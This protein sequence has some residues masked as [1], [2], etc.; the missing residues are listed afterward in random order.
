M[1]D[2]LFV[3]YIILDTFILYTSSRENVSFA[4]VFLVMFPPYIRP[5]TLLNWTLLSK[6]CN[7]HLSC[8]PNAVYSA[9]YSLR[10]IKAALLWHCNCSCSHFLFISHRLIIWVCLWSYFSHQCWKPRA[11]SLFSINRYE[12][13]CQSP[14]PSPHP[15]FISS[16]PR[17]EPS[18]PGHFRWAAGASC[19][20]N[21][22]VRVFHRGLWDSRCGMVVLGCGC[23][24]AQGA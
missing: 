18:H 16:Q 13:T 12:E 21:S 5:T 22:A 6:P 20:K 23:G 7:Y 4:A 8:Q 2:L 14:S 19:C 9:L 24:E 11:H 3:N 10:F 17:G 1:G 15:P